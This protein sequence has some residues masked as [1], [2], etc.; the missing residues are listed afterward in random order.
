MMGRTPEPQNPGIPWSPLGAPL[1][2]ATPHSP[3][4]APTLQDGAV[5]LTPSQ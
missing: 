4:T 3:P 5:L 2:L 1:L